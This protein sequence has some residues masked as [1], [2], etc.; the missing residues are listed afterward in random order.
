M[1]AEAALNRAIAETLKAILAG[2]PLTVAESVLARHGAELGL[3]DATR[4]GRTVTAQGE[5][6]AKRYG[7]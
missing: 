1:T 4:H 7:Y 2:R 6:W 3:C 5:I